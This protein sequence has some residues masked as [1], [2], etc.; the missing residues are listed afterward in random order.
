VSLATFELRAD[1]EGTL[2]VMTESGAFLD[3]YED[4]GS[5]ERGSALLLDAL[6]RWLEA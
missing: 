5:R 3:G 1:G 2:L 4:A 6:G